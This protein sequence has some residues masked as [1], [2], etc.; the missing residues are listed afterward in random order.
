MRIDGDA[1]IAC[2]LCL[3]YCPMAAINID[4]VA[5]IDQKECVDCGVC[6][7][8]GVCPVDCIIF[9]PAEWP[10]SIRA[11]FS[12]P[13]AIHKTT[14]VLGR[15]TEEMKTNEVTGRFKRGWIGMGCE[16]GRPGVGTRLHDVEKISKVLARQG[17]EFEPQNPL[18]FL[19]E[20]VKTGELKEDILNE[21]VLSAII[22]CL[23]P[24]EKLKDILTALKEV[25]KEVG[26]VFSVE[27]INRAEPDGS[28]PLEKIL[29]EA[30]IP[31]YINGKQNIGL[32]RPLAEGGD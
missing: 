2:G 13:R 18:T 28:Y 25:A 14:G 8:S 4:D 31:Y 9:E 26:T 23:F 27:C 7:K 5:V 12:D 10:R 17:V 32:G 3:P 16:V 11:V 30:G 29:K 24:I 6:L 21:K 1:C 20:D 22:E 15:G 19:M